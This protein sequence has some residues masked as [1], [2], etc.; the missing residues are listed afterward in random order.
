MALYSRPAT[1]SSGRVVA[2]HLKLPCSMWIHPSFHIS[3]IKPFH[4]SPLLPASQSPPPPR[5]ID[6]A[7]AFTVHCLLCSYHRGRG[8]QYLVDWEGYG[9]EEGSWV[10]A[11]H[12]LDAKLIRAFH[13]R[14]P[15]QPSKGPKMGEG[16]G[17]APNQ[18]LHWRFPLQKRR[19]RVFQ[20]WR[21][22]HLWNKRRLEGSCLSIEFPRPFA[23]LSLDG[24]RYVG[25][26]PLGRGAQSQ[27]CSGQS[28]PP[29][30]F[31]HISKPSS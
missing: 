11:P 28:L 24:L 29:Y 4:E 15:D 7:P 21:M 19:G 2:V 26:R 6:G 25:S 31:P 30:L 20:F 27:F 9:P 14:R 12:L 17:S 23:L 10:P 13:Q 22:T 8:L 16:A 1:Q 5:I 3:K 18:P